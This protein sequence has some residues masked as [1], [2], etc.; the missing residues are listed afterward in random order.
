MFINH[1]FLQQLRKYSRL[2]HIALVIFLLEYFSIAQV[3]A[4]PPPLD[5]LILAGKERIYELHFPAAEQIFV[6]A[7]K[8]FPDHPHGYVLQAYISALM[9]GLDQGNA[10]LAVRLEQQID[11]AETVS[12]AFIKRYP[13][14]PDSYF[15]LALN[16]S[17]EALYHVINRSFVKGYFSGRSSKNL[18]EQVVEMDPGY[19]DAYLGLGM[20]HYYADLLPGLLKFIAGILGFEGDRVRGRNEVYM[21]ASRGHYF[22]VEGE[23]IYH[24]IGY[25]LEGEKERAIRAIKLLYARYPTN[26]GLGLMLAYHYRRSGYIQKCIDYCERFTDEHSEVLPQITNLR[27]YNLAVSYYDLNQFPKADS[28]MRRLDEMP[29]RKSR[30]YQAAI[31]YYRGHL[32]DLRFDRE[33]A[34]SFFNKITK[35]S[36]T[37]YWY[38]RSRMHVRF[39]MDSL[40]YRYFVALNDLGS[41]QFGRSLAAARALQNELAAGKKSANEYLPLLVGDL[42]ARNLYIQRQFAEA[43]TIYESILPAV[44]KMDDD[45]RR[46]WI[47]I[48]YGRLLR[49]LKAYEKA[50]KYFEKAYKLDDDYTR[51]IVEREKFLTRRKIN[52]DQET[53]ED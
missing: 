10:P 16:K 21:A 46:S 31:D 36:Q 6:T 42:L 12:K 38:W 8:A 30:Y 26:Q 5:S 18:L 34:M 27:Y 29:T 41:R 3:P 49:E 20:F 52:T 24:S 19:N 28:L 1:R 11:A 23:F 50:L 22:R 15:Y 45:Y 47:F 4:T 51:V 25:F 9:F 13:D 35:D 43:R 44:E 39:P 17:I 14:S 48:Y 2:S 40:Q 33:T 53:G 37:L 7:Q 32:A